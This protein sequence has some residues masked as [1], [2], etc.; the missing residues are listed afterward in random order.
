MPY[1]HVSFKNRQISDCSLI[2]K[3]EHPYEYCLVEK[4]KSYVHFDKQTE[5]AVLLCK[6]KSV[7]EAE[8]KGASYLAS[9]PLRTLL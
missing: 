7:Y 5:P 3:K 9:L 1:Y 4:Y 6:A 8:I 2:T